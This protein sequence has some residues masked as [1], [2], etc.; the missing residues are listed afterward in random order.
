MFRSSTFSSESLAIHI[1]DPRWRAS[2]RVLAVAAVVL[3]LGETAAR[4]LLSDLGRRWEYWHPTAAT[5]FEFI[6]ER[7]ERGQPLQTL[8]VGD[9][10]GAADFDP[11]VFESELGSR[12]WNA[13]WSGNFPLAF[14]QTTLPL[15]TDPRLS[16]DVVIA[17]FIPSGF[18]GSNRPTPSEAA[19]LAS[20]FVQKRTS[21]QTGDY[22]YLSR[23]RSAWPFLADRLLARREP[24]SVTRFG[25]VPQRGRAT[26]EVW[27]REPVQP[28]VSALNAKRVEVLH[29]LARIAAA[30]DQRLLVVIPPSLTKSPARIAMA[31]LLRKTIPNDSEHVR[32]LD[33]MQPAFLQTA[34]FVDL[35][36]LNRDGAAKFSSHVAGL[37]ASWSRDKDRPAPAPSVNHDAA[38]H[39]PTPAATSSRSNAAQTSA[40]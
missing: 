37:I 5:K 32:L 39:A 12:A 18:S 4:V 3:V 6:R 30:R 7:A 26:P 40:R 19:L 11:S 31:Q 10:T 17:S 1:R 2:L 13:A 27:L 21:W 38:R 16:V 29:H 34:D 8:I 23:L 14:E 36:H 28:P 9:S 24:E 33:L 25:F 35:N 15:L 20:T 22:F